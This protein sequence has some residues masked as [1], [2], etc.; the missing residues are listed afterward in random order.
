MLI[1]AHCHINSLSSDTARAV[2]DKNSGYLFV[3]VSI[4]A[5][6]SLKSLDLS[7]KYGFIYSSL[8]FHPFAGEKFSS[9][10]IEEYRNLLKSNTKA[11]S[12]GEIGL[13]YKARLSSLEQ[14]NIFREFIKLSLEFK[15]PIMIH[16]R[17]HDDTVFGILDDYLPDYR[18]VVFH[19]FSEDVRFLA[20]ILAK[21]GNAS[22][23]LNILRKKKKIDDALKEIP[24]DNLLLET[25]SPYMKVYGEYSTPLDIKKV[26]NY[27]AGTK[28]ISVDEI[29]NA[30]YSNAKRVF[31]F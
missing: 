14:S 25:D 31:G 20:R 2:L 1:D 9:A 13:D 16:N 5:K 10:T 21:N 30:V 22:F 27:S 6:T 19:C 28:N 8:G 15:L 4:D 26:Y 29:K 24:L 3:D 12:I 11:V 18:H 23:S 7:G 17:W